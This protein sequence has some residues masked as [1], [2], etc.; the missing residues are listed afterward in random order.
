MLYSNIFF[1]C[2]DRPT[3]IKINNNGSF[4]ASLIDNIIT[5]DIDSKIKSGVLVTDL[6]DHFPT[7]TFT[8]N[9]SEHST[10]SN[11]SYQ[12]KRQLK[13]TNIKG[14][15]NA[16]SIVEW[17]LICDDTDPEMSYNKF[18]NKVMN[19]L[20]IHCPITKTKLHKHNIPK[21]PWVTRGLIKSI[22]S[23]DKLYKKYLNNP[24]F[25]NKTRYTKY[26]NHLHQLLRFSKK[27]HI[28]SELEL[29]KYNMKKTWETLNNLLGR[30]KQNKMPD[31]FTNKDGVKLTK[32]SDIA[33]GFNDYFTSIGSTLASKIPNP[34]PDYVSPLKSIHHNNSVFLSPTSSDEIDTITKDLKNSFSSGFDDISPNLLKSIVPEIKG[35]LAKIFNASL[36]TG[37]VPSKLKI[38]KVTPI[39]IHSF[40]HF[41]FHITTLYIQ[42][43]R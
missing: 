23:K 41:I 29:H 19:L 1:P 40:I 7:F 28:T 16:L 17:E 20:N 33:S 35:I 6:S 8:N 32:A 38:A 9:K 26:R 39:F 43:G 3:R 4:S 10:R 5:N 21:K 30:N 11:A 15:K 31:F 14:F 34:D 37:T 36:A 2:I 12:Y 18:H 27:S 42:S 25:E 24:S 13:P 22:Q